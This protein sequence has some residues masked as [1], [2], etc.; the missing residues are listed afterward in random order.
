MPPTCLYTSIAVS[1]HA[2]IETTDSDLEDL[3]LDLH[4]GI[5]EVLDNLWC[6]LAPLDGLMHVSD[7]FYWI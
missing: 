7:V 1:R 6:I 3:L 4:Q 5:V 2:P